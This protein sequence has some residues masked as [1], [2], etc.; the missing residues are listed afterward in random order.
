MVH[1]EP[2]LWMVSSLLLSFEAFSWNG[3]LTVSLDDHTHTK[4][5]YLNRVFPKH[6][7]QDGLEVEYSEVSYILLARSNP[8][9]A[10]LQYTVWI[11]IRLRRG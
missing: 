11:P 7:I 1:T 9:T 3:L 6:D 10:S 5:P 8:T 4:G 2:V